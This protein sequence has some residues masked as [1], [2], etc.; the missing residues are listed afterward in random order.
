MCATNKIFWDTDRISM[1]TNH[2]NAKTHRHYMLQIFIGIEDMVDISINSQS[3]KCKF[4]VIDRNIPHSFSTN[5]KIYYSS[6]IDPTSVYAQKLMDI[7]GDNKYFVCDPVNYLQLLQQGKKLLYNSTKEEYEKFEQ[8]I[9]ECLDI[10]TNDK[11]YDARIIKVFQILNSCGYNNL[12]IAD[13]ADAVAISHSR[14][15]HL[16]KEQTGIPLKSYILLHQLEL[17]FIELFAGKNVTQASMLAGF[18]SPS[19]LAS[20]V[21]R[22]M[23]MPVSL[24]L[25]NSEFLKVY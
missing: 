14:L 17:V 20:T 7:I 22:M 19:H 8:L 9:N 3:I 10:S 16:F 6:L 25:K 5:N 21:K 15:S 24:S 12:R 11:K 18:D 23:G 4:I 2:I 13:L 1:I